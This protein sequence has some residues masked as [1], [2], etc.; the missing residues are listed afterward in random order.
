MQKK[1]IVQRVCKELEIN[2]TKLGKRLGVSQS[3]ISDWNNGKIPKM[4]QLALELL[5]ENKQQK[6]KLQKVAE[7]Y[8][9]IREI[10]QN[11]TNL[12]EIR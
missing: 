5:I 12:L 9:I 3:S 6:E 1:N 4:A 11:E 10:N 2:Q 8:E 7:F